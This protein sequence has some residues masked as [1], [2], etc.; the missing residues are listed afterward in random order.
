MAKTILK[1]TNLRKSYYAFGGERLV[2]NNVSLALYKGDVFGFLGPNGAG[3]TTTIKMLVD[4]VR[5]DLGTIR[6]FGESNRELAVRRR[7]GFMSE[8]PQFYEYLTGAEVLEFTGALFGMTKQQS[9]AK[10]IELLALVGLAE[11][12]QLPTRA[13]SKGMAQRLGFAQALMNEPELLLL[14]EPLDGLDPLGRIE[15]KNIIKR[16]RAAGATI[17]FNSHILSDVE[18]ICNRVAII[19]EGRVLAE[20]SVRQIKG[21][22][23]TLE[24]AFVALVKDHQ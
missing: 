10:A 5:P 6:L 1:I 9:R 8:N 17:F 11:A 14:D 4:L 2:V 20:G 23:P 12:K 19:H 15:F 21:K 22:A 18:E 24:A 13:Y 3:K 7:L 16:L